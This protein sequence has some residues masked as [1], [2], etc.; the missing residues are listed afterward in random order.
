MNDKQLSTLKTYT[1]ALKE[2]ES[3][4]QKEQSALEIGIQF[5][6]DLGY[7]ETSAISSSKFDFTGVVTL[8]DYLY[9]VANSLNPLFKKTIGDI[10]IL[11]T[12]AILLKD[13]KDDPT[14]INIAQNYG[15]KFYK[16]IGATTWTIKDQLE[17]D[18]LQPF[19]T[20]SSD[21][22]LSPTTQLASIS[23]YSLSYD[24]V[25]NYLIS[26]G[27]NYN[28]GFDFDVILGPISYQ[29]DLELLYSGSEYFL[30]SA[31]TEGIE[32][33]TNHGLSK[34]EAR[35]QTIKDINVILGS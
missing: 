14:K 24:V 33:Y 2:A 13:A 27:A 8:E 6:K 19:D 9:N 4:K 22:S 29:V 18:K 21:T 15:T 31:L 10:P 3:D 28:I 12:Y 1:T 11:E 32:F 34:D 7:D 26:V 35:Y 23:E 16:L 5:Y 30:N 25:R 20:A 17:M